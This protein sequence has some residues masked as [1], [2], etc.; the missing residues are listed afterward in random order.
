MA[1]SADV[2]IGLHFV[3]AQVFRTFLGKDADLMALLRAKNQGK[4]KLSR[5]GAGRARRDTGGRLELSG[6]DFP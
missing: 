3:T 2:L 5:S 4:S 6:H 1:G